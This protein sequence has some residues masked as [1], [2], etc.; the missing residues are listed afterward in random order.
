MAF[1]AAGAPELPFYYYHI[2]A[3]TGVDVDLV[4]FLRRAGDRVD[5]LAGLKYTANTLH[6]YQECVA[7]DEGRF[8]VLYG[9]DELLLP[10]LAVGARGAV[11]STYNIAAPLYRRIIEAFE[12]GDL[13]RARAEQLHAIEMIRTLAHYPFHPAVKAVLGMVGAPCGPCRL[14]LPPLGDAEV[15]QLR[16]ELEAIGFFDWA[17]HPKDA[18]LE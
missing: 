16:G 11:G 2:P 12:A 17:R 10:A 9:Y 1:V 7:L 4:E 5:N 14:P 18:S 6:E 3:M 13:A 8:D 15:Q